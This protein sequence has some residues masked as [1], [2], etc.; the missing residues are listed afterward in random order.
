MRNL[1][2]AAILFAGLCLLA[3]GQAMAAPPP[4]ADH[5]A[6][7]KA[8]AASLIDEVRHKRIE[9]QTYVRRKAVKYK[10]RYDWTYYPYWRPYQYR[11]W[12]YIYPYGGPLF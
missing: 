5:A 11:Y 10:R 3:P 4:L 7:S 6:S 9:K 12:Q 2:A 8:Q 1:I